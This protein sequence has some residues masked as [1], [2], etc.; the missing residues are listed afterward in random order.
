M[1]RSKKEEPWSVCD[2]FSIP[3]FAL[4]LF[5]NELAQSAPT[6][7]WT[8]VNP[9]ILVVTTCRWIPTARL[10][11]ALD[12][13]GCTVEAVCPS[14]HPLG[15]TRLGC[16]MHPYRDLMPLR[17]IKDAILA[18]KPDLIIPGDDLATQHLHE[19]YC[20]EQPPGKT[21]A[22][23]ELIERSLGAPQ[24]FSIVYARTTFMECAQEGGVRVPKSEVI[25]NIEALRKWAARSGF[26]TVLKADGTSGGDGVRV[27]HTLEEAE[28]AFQALQAPPL[29]SR[30]VKRALLDQ[31]K[32]LFW[33]YLLRRRAVVNAQTFVAGREATSAI[34]CWKGTVLAELHFEV[35]RKVDDAGPSTVVRLIENADMSFAAE[36]IVRRL[37]LSGLHGFDFMLEANTGNAY[38]L[39]INPRAT[40]VGYLALGWGRDLPAAL[41]AAISGEPVRTARKVTENDVIALFPQEWNGDPESPFL[42]SGYHDIPWEEPELV[43]DCIRM[44]RKQRPWYTK[45][46]WLQSLL[47]IRSS[48][49]SPLS[50]RP[51]H[52]AMEMDCEAK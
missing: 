22:L 5:L 28:S 19:L 9:K 16:K 38:L 4:T 20:R 17:S 10:A 46:N 40:Q 7:G 34:A 18:V 48:S 2:A 41:F 24:S 52:R 30:A 32:R 37:N 8:R 31:D 36:K 1:N 11:M 3:C 51:E 33:P 23:S 39:E 49:S 26:P 15:K 27:V 44:G 12:N 6:E 45:Q 50:A 47:A 42:Q 35:L 13:A 29:L 43:K 21:G 25:T 14:H